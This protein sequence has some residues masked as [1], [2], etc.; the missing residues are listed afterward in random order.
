MR[1]ETGSNTVRI[2]ASHRFNNYS[3]PYF[4]ADEYTPTP[5]QLGMIFEEAN[6]LGFTNIIFAPYLDPNLELELSC[7]YTDTNYSKPACSSNSTWRGFWGQL[8]T[9]DDWNTF[10]KNYNELVLS[11]IPLLNKYNISDYCI[12]TELKTMIQTHSQQFIP[13]VA[14]V[15]SNGYKGRITIDFDK[16]TD[17]NTMQVFLL[18]DK[19]DY[20]G[21]SGYYPLDIVAKD[22]MPWTNPTLDDVITAWQPII[23]ELKNISISSG[24]KKIIFTEGTI[25]PFYTTPTIHSH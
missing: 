21:I 2:I 4:Y 8:W 3:T 10:F 14:N 16:T 7:I 9:D 25:S 17:I 12:S 5:Q 11:Y 22:S 23:E 20:I 1:D 6:N 15:K 13:I 19:L 18:L 24:N